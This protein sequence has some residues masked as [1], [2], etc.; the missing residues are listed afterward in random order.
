[1]NS[2]GVEVALAALVP[3]AVALAAA[4]RFGDDATWRATARW[5]VPLVLL[6]L[7]PCWL[8]GRSP[9]AFGFLHTSVSPWSADVV[10]E[11]KGATELSDVV[12]QFAPWRETVTRRW[13]D[14]EMPWLDR[15]AA[16]GSVLWANPQALVAHPLTLAGLP[17][18]T[19]AWFVFVASAKL[20]VG[21]GGMFLFLRRERVS[22]AAS[23][24]GAVAYAFSAFSI[25]WLLFPHTNVTMLLPWLLVAIRGAVVGGSWRSA[26]GGAIVLALM[27]AGGHPESVAHSAVVALPYAGSLV[28][29]AGR[30]AGR[31]AILRLTAIGV[32]GLLLAAPLLIPF[33]TALEGSERMARWERMPRFWT[34]PPMT[35]GN[36]RPFVNGTVALF[37]SARPDFNETGTQ[38]AG[39]LAIALASCGAV[40]LARRER[41]WL[42]LFAVSA[43]LAF[44]WPPSRWLEAVPLAG[45]MLHGRLRFVL[46]FV[47]ATLAAKAIDDIVESKSRRDV[48]VSIAVCIGASL[49]SVATARGELSSG[50]FALPAGIATA[51]ALAAA[52]VALLLMKATPPAFRSAAPLLIFADLFAL[53]WLFNAP[54]SRRLAY[55]PMPGLA[56]IAP[57]SGPSRVAGIDI[58]LLANTGAMVGVEEI[59]AH[60][61]MAWDG[62]VELLRRAGYDTGDYFAQWKQVPPKLLLDYLGVTTLVAPAGIRIAGLDVA[63]AGRDLTVYRNAGALPRAFAASRV[64]ATPDPLAS[65]TRSRDPRAVSVAA[66]NGDVPVAPARVRIESYDGNGEVIRVECERGTFIATSEVALRGWRLERDAAKWPLVRVNGIFLGWRVPPGGG[67]FTLRYRPPGIEAGLAL[68]LLGLV[69]LVAMLGRDDELPH[70]TLPGSSL[71][72]PRP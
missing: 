44:D 20:L 57:A 56:A 10:D 14:G 71:P 34:A 15:H 68:T 2:A 66:S 62:Y 54:V 63:Y 32:V 25:A 27:C 23:I 67:V 19:F 12:M 8:T 38:Y 37:G 43:V 21:L 42:A 30:G 26:G 58:A 35:P 46:V 7:A 29:R 24:F 18:T 65:F 59:G 41:L 48:L 28:L 22:E 5:F 70:T 3:A 31:S 16:S 69:A 36:L 60:D 4:R 53:L 47:V 11:A 49:A 52:L 39:L 61:P 6:W 64:V 50:G 13:L 33:A 1:M 45:Q 40:R 72:P 9:V 51:V 17:F 55:P